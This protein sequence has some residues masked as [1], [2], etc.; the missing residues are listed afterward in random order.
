MLVRW[1]FRLREVKAAET[2]KLAREEARNVLE[3]F[4]YRARDLIEQPSFIESSL[5][6]E[7]KTIKEKTETANEWLWDEADS[8]P[9]KD[10]KA[11]K[12]DLE[13]VPP[14]PPSPFLSFPGRR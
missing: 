10:L 13:C 9:T 6:S 1:V 8:A 3:A 14:P 2:R 5:E 7:R 11:K 12:A 4:I